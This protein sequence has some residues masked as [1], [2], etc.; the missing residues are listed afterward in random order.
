MK[1]RQIQ[2]KRNQ[3][4]KLFYPQMKRALKAQAADVLAAIKV[5][6][7]TAI[8]QAENMPTAPLERVFGKIYYKTGMDFGRMQIDTVKSRYKVL[9]R[10]DDE[11]IYLEEV[12]RY[13]RTAIG[14]RIVSVT[15]T[16]KKLLV[17]ILKDEIAEGME[18]GEGVAKLAERLTAAWKDYEDL[19]DWRALRITS[20]EVHTASNLGQVASMD[21]TGY[22][23]EKQWQTGGNNIRD[24]HADLDDGEWYPQDHVFTN[25]VPVAGGMVQSERLRF[26]GDG[27]LGASAGNIVNCKCLLDFRLI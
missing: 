22:E 20:T 17:S 1:W 5:N 26:P 11:D 8:G 3:Y 12:I 9:D 21:S 18:A 10:K 25:S 4:V 27:E 7:Y 6:P 2:R 15:G 24:A 13:S 23:Y 19:I 14:S 16:S